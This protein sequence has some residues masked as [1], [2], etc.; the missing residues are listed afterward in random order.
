MMNY[1]VL[2]QS[3]LSRPWLVL[4]HLRLAFTRLIARYGS[5]SRR[6]AQL[7]ESCASVRDP[8]EKCGLVRIV[9]KAGNNS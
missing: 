3:R 2:R 1:K 4:A 8:G 6:G 9:A 5:R 7:H